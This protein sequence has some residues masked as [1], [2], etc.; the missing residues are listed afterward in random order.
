MYTVWVLALPN[1]DIEGC[2]VTRTDTPHHVM[3]ALWWKDSLPIKDGYPEHVLHEYL[4]KNLTATQTLFAKVKKRAGM[5][6]LNVKEV[7]QLEKL[8][9]NP[10][11][12]WNQPESP[13]G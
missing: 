4:L 5:T 11:T 3:D 6:A 10:A 2:W 12:S 8:L 1:Q 13:L 9:T 7:L